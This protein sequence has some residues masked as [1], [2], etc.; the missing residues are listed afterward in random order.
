MLLTPAIAGRSIGKL[1]SRSSIARSV[2]WRVC[3]PAMDLSSPTPGQLAAPLSTAKAHPQ[4]FTGP[5]SDSVSSSKW[6]LAGGRP[7][8]TH[9]SSSP[10]TKMPSAAY[11]A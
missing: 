1:S 6:A 8:M 9:V 11:G 4:S 3:G 2:S 10:M 5:C 7:G